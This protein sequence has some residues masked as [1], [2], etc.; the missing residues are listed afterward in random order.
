[1]SRAREAP[2]EVATP[3]TR[4]YLILLA[5]LGGDAHGLGI[6]R[7][8]E[9]LSEGRVRLWPATLYGTLEDLVDAGWIEPLDDADEKP[10][11]AG[12][13]KRF[14]RITARGRAL[15]RGET[16]RLAELVRVARARVRARGETA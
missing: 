3:K 13:R 16:R 6:A 14:Y 4:H 10:R 1:M 15:A 2:H 7:E 12:E 9:R 5:L 11:D 8:V